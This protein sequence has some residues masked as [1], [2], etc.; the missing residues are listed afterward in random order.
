MTGPKETG[1]KLIQILPINDTIATHSWMDSY[2]YA[3]ISAFALHPLYINL[4]KVA[5]KKHADKVSA[6]KKKQKQLNELPVMDYE[7]VMRF[8]IAMLK[9]LYEVM[10]KD[11]FES[12][13][14]KEFF[15][16]NKH[17]LEPYA[18]FCFF[19]D[20]YGSSHFEEWKTNGVV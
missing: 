14:Y 17:W 2:P 7:E 6:L 13:D 19:R 11:C 1:L 9:E 15:E 5:G 8:K 10:G 3:A 12:E 20:K 16:E 4:A 18:A